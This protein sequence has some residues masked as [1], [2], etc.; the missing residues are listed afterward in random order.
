MN[1]G[2]AY[3]LYGDKSLVL[4][5]K[6][7]LHKEGISVSQADVP[8]SLYAQCKTCLITSIEDSFS[9]EAILE[10]NRIYVDSVHKQVAVWNG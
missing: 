4:E 1:S 6:E 5:S 7:I 3:F 2:Y 9:A 8:E 10:Q